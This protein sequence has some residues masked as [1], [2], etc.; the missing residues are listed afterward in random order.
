[1][2]TK[3]MIRWMDSVTV[4]I[5]RKEMTAETMSN[6]ENDERKYMLGP[7]CKSND[8]VAFANKLIPLLRLTDFD[9][10]SYKFYLFKLD[11][12]QSLAINTKERVLTSLHVINRKH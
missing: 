11:F 6:I 9:M 1:M 2:K 3:E 8:N 10:S 7:P 4:V 12:H 5:V